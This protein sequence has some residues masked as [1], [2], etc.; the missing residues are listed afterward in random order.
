MLD[1]KNLANSKHEI[2]C[3]IE[4]NCHRNVQFVM[5][6]VWKRSQ[7][8]FKYSHEMTLENATGHEKPTWK[9]VHLPMEIPL[10]ATPLK[11]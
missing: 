11:K 10:K 9:C 6:G 4:G 2:P 3:E 5:C 1:K 8:Y 7:N